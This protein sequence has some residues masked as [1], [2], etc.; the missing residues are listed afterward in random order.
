VQHSPTSAA[1]LTS[2]ILNHAPN[3]PELNALITKFSE[4]YSSINMS[5]D[6]KILKKSISWLN[7]GNALIEHFFQ[8]K[9]AIFV[10]PVLPGSA[11]A[12]VT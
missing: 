4:S 5:R 2:F 12:Q 7:S 9:S 1:L 10:F 11:E 8:V 3:S 6:S